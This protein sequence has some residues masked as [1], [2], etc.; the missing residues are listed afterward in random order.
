MN[1]RG[2][3]VARGPWA[4]WHITSARALYFKVGILPNGKAGT[5]VRTGP[6][7]CM[8]K[9]EDPTN[10]KCTGAGVV[11]EEKDLVPVCQRTLRTLRALLKD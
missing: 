11:L 8:C 5:V 7:Q 10:T 2:R 3:V 6:L 1:W 4:G 9:L